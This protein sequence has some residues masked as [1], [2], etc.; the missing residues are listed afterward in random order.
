MN[1]SVLLYFA[2]GSNLLSERFLI[3]NKGTR[4]GIGRLEDYSLGF[5]LPDDYWE[6]NVLTIMPRKGSY[7]MGAV[8]ELTTDIRF[9]DE[10]EEGYFPFT[11]DIKMYN[12]KTVACR[13]YQLID[14]PKEDDED[15]NLPSLSYLKAIVKGAVESKLPEDY[16]KYLR[17]FKH[18]GNL[19]S[20]REDALQ[21]H[22]FKL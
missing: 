9:L 12:G 3:N 19:V 18:N 11:V 21:L 22:D 15:H 10:Q 2:Y 13:T 5:S 1:A 20:H 17:G 7:V 6:G 4:M 16:I 8:W 14:L